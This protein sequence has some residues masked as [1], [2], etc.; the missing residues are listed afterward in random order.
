MLRL[1]RTGIRNLA[2]SDLIYSRGLQ[3]YKSN[4]VVN[5]AFSKLSGQY[6][7]TVRGSYNYSVIITE[8][9]DGSF[10]HF[11]NCPAHVKE[12]GACK[13][14]VAALLFILKYQEKSLMEEPQSP[15]EKKAFQVLEY[16]A[17]QEETKTQGEIFH[18]EAIIFIPPF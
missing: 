9:K 5:A 11:C 4:R 14:V 15:E 17:N 18:I 8:N 6:K 2:S 12:K 16:F 13:H 10:E 3:Y 7:L 1:S